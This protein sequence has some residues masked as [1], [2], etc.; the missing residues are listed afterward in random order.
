MP[1]SF[2]KY[3]S[4]IK[5]KSKEFSNGMDV[6][7]RI[8]SILKFKKSGSVLDLGSGNGRHSLFFAKKG[9]KVTALDND[10]ALLSDIKRTA[11]EKGLSITTKYCD[12]K[13][14]QPSR[15]FDVIIASMSLHFLK[16][17]QAIKAIQMMKNQ[18][19]IGGINYISNFTDKHPI[20]TRSYLT[21]KNE[22]RG[23]YEDWRVQ[24]YEEKMG[25]WFYSKKQGKNVRKHRAVILAKNRGVLSEV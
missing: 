19:K 7:P 9:F 22:L 1:L 25:P 21:K 20:G 4:T 14:Y 17:P 18:T 11:K 23:Y 15:K 6:S 5:R 8:R 12:I 16:K 3:M 24:A 13:K 2:L 10:K